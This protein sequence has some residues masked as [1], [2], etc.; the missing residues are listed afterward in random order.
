VKTV[1]LFRYSLLWRRYRSFKR[2]ADEKH[3][4]LC[5][6][7]AE[8][9]AAVPPDHENAGREATV[10]SFRRQAAEV[11]AAGAELDAARRFLVA[12]ALELQAADIQRA[13]DRIDAAA[14]KLAALNMTHFQQRMDAAIAMH[15]SG[16]DVDQ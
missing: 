13:A 9:V 5:N 15:F 7:C 3:T 6:L 4:R 1:N 8:L 2:F 10:E 12:C 14:D 11:R 16:A